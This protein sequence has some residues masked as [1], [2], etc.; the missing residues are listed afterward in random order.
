MYYRRDCS[1]EGF[2]QDISLAKARLLC[3]HPFVGAAHFDRY[4]RDG[5]VERLAVGR[6]GVLG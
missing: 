3:L 6:P 5:N 2:A 4:I 1:V